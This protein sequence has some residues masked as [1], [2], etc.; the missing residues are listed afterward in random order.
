MYNHVLTCSNGV[1]TYTCGAEASPTKDETVLFWPDDFGLSGEQTTELI[2]DLDAWA[3]TQGFKYEIYRGP[4]CVT[5]NDV[6][7]V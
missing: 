3:K 6:N 2:K 7:Q 4:R 1:H 5:T